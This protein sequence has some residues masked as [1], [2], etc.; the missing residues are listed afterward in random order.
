MNL[1]NGWMGGEGRGT[2]GWVDWL[3]GRN[4]SGRQREGEGERKFGTA[5][6]AGYHAEFQVFLIALLN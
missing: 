4:R 2:A 3:D 1:T 6:R 5:C